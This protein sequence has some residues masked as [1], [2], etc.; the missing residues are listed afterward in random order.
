MQS[1]SLTSL[2]Q[3]LFGMLQERVTQCGESFEKNR[4]IRLYYDQKERDNYRASDHPVAQPMNQCFVAFKR[5]VVEVLNARFAVEHAGKLQL[6]DARNLCEESFN[7]LV[8]TANR[9][10]GRHLE[11]LGDIN[12]LME[13]AGAMYVIAGAKQPLS[14]VEATKQAR[15][16]LRDRSGP[17]VMEL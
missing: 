5:G 4:L 11:S 6:R 13:T 15:E 1:V 3:E 7:D 2:P 17:G 8:N 9:L 12:E 14:V 16:M 10:K